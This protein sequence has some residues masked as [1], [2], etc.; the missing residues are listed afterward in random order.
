MLYAEIQAFRK[1]VIMMFLRSQL[2]AKVKKQIHL[3]KKFFFIENTGLIFRW[4]YPNFLMANDQ[5]LIMCLRF[6]QKTRWNI[7]RSETGKMT[8]TYMLAF[9]VYEHQVRLNKC[10]CF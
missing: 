5:T 10:Q 4:T 1:S 7:S 6:M 3:K 2:I 9:E 8:E